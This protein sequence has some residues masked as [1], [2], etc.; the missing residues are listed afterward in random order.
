MQAYGGNIAVIE[1]FIE[2]E[3]NNYELAKALLVFAK[4]RWDN[5]RLQEDYL[6]IYFFKSS[7]SL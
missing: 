2:L 4:K 1:M 6:T 7:M 5:P 3:N